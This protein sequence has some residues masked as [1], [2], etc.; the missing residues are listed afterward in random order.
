[1]AS[2][3]DTHIRLSASISWPHGSS[4]NFVV[5]LTNN[6]TLVNPNLCVKYVD[7]KVQRRLCVEY[8]GGWKCLGP[9]ISLS[10]PVFLSRERYYHVIELP[11]CSIR[12]GWLIWKIR[13]SVVCNSASKRYI[14]SG[15][16]MI[17]I[18]IRL[19]D[20]WWVISFYCTFVIMINNLYWK[21]K[22]TGCM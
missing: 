9:C 6:P 11:V 17:K 4:H 21:F 20:G 10:C 22:L 2:F 19:F 7:L 13:C 14:R 8:W 16:S 5:I 12:V 3:G 1:M 15:N 18:M